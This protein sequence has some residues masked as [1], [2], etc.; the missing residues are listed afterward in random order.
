MFPGKKDR[1]IERRRRLSVEATGDVMRRCRLRWH[2][3]V[4][5]KD[6]VD[7]VKAYTRLVVEGKAPVGRLRKT[8][9]NTLSADMRLLKV[10]PLGRPQPKDIDGQDGARNT[11]LKQRR[12]RAVFRERFIQKVESKI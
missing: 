4:E 8:R 9:Q 3:H 6:D 2:G 10:D 12:T 7:Y 1:L 11:A 5:R